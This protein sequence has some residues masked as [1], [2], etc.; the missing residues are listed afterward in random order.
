M[1][2]GQ[3]ASSSASTLWSRAGVPEHR[4]PTIVIEA[5]PQT[6]RGRVAALWRYRGFYGFLFKE[7]TTRK[8][9]G[10][11]L[12]FWW[13][14]IRPLIPAAGL[15]FLFGNVQPLETGV[16]YP[17]FFLSGYIPWRVFQSAMMYLPR[18]L[19][20]T[21][22]IMRRTYFPRLL[23]PLAGFGMTFIELGL[24]LVVFAIAVALNAANGGPPPLLGWHTL[25]LLPCLLAALFLALA[26][27]LVFSVVA[28]FF[29]DVIFSLRFFSQVFMF[30]TPVIYPVTF[31]P[32]AYRWALY[33]LNPMAQVVLVSRWALTGQGEF[34]LPFVLLSFGTI[35]AALAGGLAFFL[36]AETHLGDQM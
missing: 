11:L 9:R 35:L 4:Q 2:N 24:L 16:P 32:E 3:D 17:I 23:V 5:R 7:I 29:R 19:T 13:L 14:I 18:T 15:I 30:L 6:L 25:W 21:Q 34:D 20:W 26:F 8:S 1:T 12:G 28:L 10:T 36:R 33:A 31:V 27:G 22:G